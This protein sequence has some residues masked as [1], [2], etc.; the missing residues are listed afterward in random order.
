[1]RWGWGG[2]WLRSGAAWAVS[3]LVGVGTEL[4]LELEGRRRDH[5]SIDFCS[6]TAYSAVSA[7]QTYSL[8]ELLNHAAIDPGLLVE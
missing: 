4:E 7:Y 5:S 1:M 8:P 6:L 2:W 3:R